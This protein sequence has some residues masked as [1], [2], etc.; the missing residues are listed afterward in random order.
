MTILDIRF[1]YHW[2]PFLLQKAVKDRW[3]G[4][5]IWKKWKTKVYMY[6]IYAHPLK[7]LLFVFF[8]FKFPVVGSSLGVTGKV[9]IPDSERSGKLFL[10]LQLVSYLLIHIIKTVPIYSLTKTS[11]FR[12]WS[13]VVNESILGL[14]DYRIIFRT[15]FFTWLPECIKKIAYLLCSSVLVQRSTSLDPLET[16]R[17]NKVIQINVY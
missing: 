5:I 17:K 7:M 4:Q 16:L 11:L 8:F 2:V 12:P 3:V 15:I 6:H 9:V 14:L 1:R 10:L 13:R